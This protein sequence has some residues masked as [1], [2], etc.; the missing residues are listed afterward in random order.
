MTSCLR[1]DLAETTG[2]DSMEGT[3]VDSHTADSDVEPWLR[4][5]PGNVSGLEDYVL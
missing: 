1:C 2:I 3:E 5:S 4:G